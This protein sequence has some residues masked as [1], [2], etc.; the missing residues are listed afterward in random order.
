MCCLFGLI[1]YGHT[2]SGRQKTKILQA[3]A[4]ESEARGTDAA[5][6]AYYNE[7]RL[8]VN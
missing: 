1:D 7:G 6:I 8:C 5:G 3:L 4:L 2:L